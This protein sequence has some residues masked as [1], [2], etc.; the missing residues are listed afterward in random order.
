MAKQA[1]H[2]TDEEL[3]GRLLEGDAEAFEMLYDRRQGNVYRFALRMSGSPAIAEDVTQDVFIALLSNQVR[4]DQAIGTVAGYL[5]GMARHRVLRRLDRERAFV[6]LTAEDGEEEAAAVDRMVV[7]DDPLIELSR[8][9]TIEAVR[10]AV[11]ALPVH[12]REAIVLC[13]LDEM[14]YEQ[15]AGVIGCPI[16]TVRSRLNRGRALLV[17]KLKAAQGQRNGQWSGGYDRGAN[18][19]PNRELVSVP[20]A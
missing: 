5:M 1:V 10:Q 8:A 4:F 20:R 6:S 14:S 3:M 18:A 15:A 16:G 7:N 13:D 2:P 19:D 9:D 11:L 12:Y 17:E